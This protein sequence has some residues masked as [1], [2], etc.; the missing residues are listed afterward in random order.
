MS[1]FRLSRTVPGIFIL[2]I[3]IMMGVS[4]SSRRLSTATAQTA[5]PQFAV[6]ALQGGLAPPELGGTYSNIR[7]SSVTDSGEVAFSADI[8]GSAA[9]S[10][11]LLNSAG[12]TRVILRSGDSTPAGGTFTAFD[13]LD[14][15]D[16]DFLLFRAGLQ[17]V[18]SS[19][20]VFLWTPQGVQTVQLAGD[21]TNGRYP[22]QFTYSSFG[23][24]TIIPTE[25]STG[26]P[27]ASYAFVA[28]LDGD[29]SQAVVWNQD[30]QASV[31]LTFA[32]SGVGQFILEPNE[33]VDGFVL[34]PLSPSDLTV[35]AD[36][37]RVDTN[38]HFTR[39]FSIPFSDPG[40]DF[41][42]LWDPSFTEG[43]HTTFGKLVQMASPAGS[44]L[45]GAIYILAEFSKSGRESKAIL[46][47]GPGSLAPLL[48]TG[49]RAPG[50]QDQKI[51]DIGLPVANQGSIAAFPYP[52]PGVVSTVQLSDG[53][54]ALWVSLL[55]PGSNASLALIGGATG[56]SAQPV[57]TSFNPVK[58]TNTGTLLISGSVA[59]QNGLF[60]LSGLF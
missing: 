28:S 43:L 12:A 52:P 3:A 33:I 17:G 31:A 18:P 27:D 58:L 13:E 38:K 15:A 47:Y 19:E 24:L 23:Q 7:S 45:D 6:I 26:G 42:I 53:Q 8:S 20:G 34:A 49:D 5:Q 2:L 57:L 22:G 9:T 50:L 4:P 32:V 35:V 21:K 37:H 48:H 60:V 40:G 30:I 36:C 10:A 16:G 44:Y 51:K 54:N 46:S 59:A 14:I 11:I 55:T 1:L 39:P 25:D 56:S 41:S 29:Q